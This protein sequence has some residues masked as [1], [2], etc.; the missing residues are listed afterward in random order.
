MPAADLELAMTIDP[1][2]FKT[3]LVR[4]TL[5]T[6]A[7]R[8]V[9]ALTLDLSPGEAAL[10]LGLGRGGATSEP[11]AQWH[12]SWAAATGGL[13]IA[14][15]ALGLV[16]E[17]VLPALAVAF[18]RAAGQGSIAGLTTGLLLAL[19]PLGMAVGARSDSGASAAL[20]ALAAL[21]LLREG[22]RTASQPW[23]LAS[24]TVVA[25]LGVW[26]PAALVVVPAGLYVVLRAVA[27]AEVKRVAWLGWPLA[28]LAALGVRA[29]APG[30]VLTEPHAAAEWLTQTANAA[31][32]SQWL[33]QPAL[34]V[35]LAALAAVVPIGPAG[36]LA[37]QL[38]VAAAPL[39]AWIGGSVLM[40][41]SVVGAVRGLVQ[42]DPPRPAAGGAAGPFGA[43]AGAA[44]GWRTLGAGTATTPRTLG[45]R[46]WGPGLLLVLGAAGFAAIQ[47]LRG[48]IDGVPD[49]L[50][51]GRVGAALLFGP[52]LAALGAPRSAQ[53][54]A[55]D[56]RFQRRFYW[57][58][59][60]VALGVFALGAWQLLL[61]TS[62]PSRTLAKN[63]ARQVHALVGQDGA[64]LALGRRGLPIAAML[65]AGHVTGRIEASQLAGPQPLAALV[66]LL[67]A[68]PPVVVLT[69]DA[70]ALGLAEPGAT[71]VRPELVAVRQ[72]LE[73]TL[74]AS[75]YE[76]DDNA[77]FVRA[78]LGVLTFTRGGGGDPRAIRPQLGPDQPPLP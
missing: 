10:A 57:T 31:A 54:Q 28:A 64:A 19:G 73:P 25:L 51:A 12:H 22:L 55:A 4:L 71:L 27:M 40:L 41:A 47:Q 63:A 3:L 48:A 39:W 44:D 16:A 52:G 49:A 33:E 23:L 50:Q 67:A 34:Q 21:Y 62:D 17:A 66:R 29:V 74:L 53:G 59:G 1:K 76:L 13:A 26:A 61:Q 56:P 8:L 6:L 72:L 77:A 37:A 46:D 38:D 14:A 43:G 35:A 58:L 30:F 45:D 75:G 60:V 32:P 7:V 42:A 24:A 65:D 9:P 18:A 36:A 2:D 69:G 78:G 68:K 70:D 5:V 11:L 20:G 15:R